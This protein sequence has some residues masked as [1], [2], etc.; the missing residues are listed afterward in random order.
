ML[1]RTDLPSR[2][3]P[4]CLSRAVPLNDAPVDRD[5]GVGIYASTRRTYV[6][7]KRGFTKLIQIWQ[8]GAFCR[9]QI[10]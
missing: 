7:H 5:R 10:G 6:G 8:Q 4:R 9:R 1:G 3:L 2:H